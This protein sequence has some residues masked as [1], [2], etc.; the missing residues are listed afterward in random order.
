M[1]GAPGRGPRVLS[2]RGP[3]L[4]PRPPTPPL[5]L[6]HHLVVGHQ[7]QDRLEPVP[8]AH[9]LA[10]FRVCIC[11]QR[12]GGR[13]ARCGCGATCRRAGTGCGGERQVPGSGW[14]SGT[15][16]APHQGAQQLL[17]VAADDALVLVQCPAALLGIVLAASEVCKDH[18]QPLL[19][20]AD[21]PRGQGSAQ[22]LWGG[23]G[24]GS[25]HSLPVAQGVPRTGAQPDPEVISMS[26]RPASGKG[27]GLPA[28]A[29]L[30]SVLPGPVR[31]QPS[32]L[33]S[34][35]LHPFSPHPSDPW[36]PQALAQLSAF[37]EQLHGPSREPP[38]T[39]SCSKCIQQ[40]AL[41]PSPGQM[42][43]EKDRGALAA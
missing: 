33:P 23:G 25:A 6:T 32:S 42:L 37:S 11:L 39:G 13:V 18:L 16:P 40:L 1:P 21:L 14:G 41:H 24:H 29:A 3:H 12:E 31:G 28:G 38:G 2:V 43:P 5:R 22:V 20:M 19:V 26:A 17:Q 8:L 10:H 34:T 15:G 4:G 9:F 35:P 36:L 30:G 27:P 7:G